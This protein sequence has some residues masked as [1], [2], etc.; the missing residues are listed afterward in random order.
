MHGI[1]FQSV[2][3][4]DGLDAQ[5]FGPVESRRHDVTLLKLSKLHLRMQM[6]PPGSFIYGDQAYPV[7]PWLL[8]PFRGPN[9]TH[10]MRRWSRA[11]RT[12]RISVEH[13]FKIISSLFS[14]LKFVPAQRIFGTPV[15]KQLV[16]CT[17]LANMHNCLY[18]SQVS[19]HY[20]S[21]TT[22]HQ[23][24][25]NIAT[26]THTCN[27]FVVLF[28]YLYGMCKNKCPSIFVIN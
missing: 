25:R 22:H 7:R 18:Q 10:H 5:M 15:A 20:S 6:L 21:M 8:S 19:Q 2:V 11:M 28:M 16:V 26:C 12:V 13:G 4:P 9:K 24:W 17:A 1:K 3:L 14:H 27:V 23:H